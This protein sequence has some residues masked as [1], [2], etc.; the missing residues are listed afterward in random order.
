MATVKTTI[1][2]QESLFDRVN[3]LAEELQI[4]C[5]RLF[6]LAV[7][8]FIRQHENRGIFDALNDVYDGTPDQEEEALREA[9]RRCQTRL[10]EG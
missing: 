4:P 7:E 1:S 8:R 9:T 10:V 2:I 5:S 6:T 3:D